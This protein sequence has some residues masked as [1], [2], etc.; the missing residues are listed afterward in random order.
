MTD[1]ELGVSGLSIGFTFP[2]LR[3][4][5]QAVVMALCYCLSQILYL[6]LLVPFILSTSVSCWDNS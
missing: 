4:V 3:L 5:R 1:D 2:S 6:P